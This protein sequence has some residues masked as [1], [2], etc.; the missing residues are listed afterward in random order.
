RVI[1]AGAI[2]MSLC[3]P[4][5]DFTHQPI[6]FAALVALA[7]TA[8][9]LKVTLPLTASG[10][11]MSVSYAVDFA[12]LLL[13]GPHE[14]MVVAVAS[15]FCQSHVNTKDR[16]PLYRTIFNMAALVLTVQGAGLALLWLT[17]PSADAVSMIARPL[18]GAATTYFVLN[19]AIIATA[20]AFST[21]QPILATW[22]TNFLW[23][24][25]R[26]TRRAW[27]RP[28][29]CRRRRFR[30]SKPRPCFMT[31]GSWLFRNTSCRSP[32]R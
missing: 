10:S 23:G 19:T 20:I 22:Q 30:E 14:T 18:V 2:V 7:S 21:A 17:D 15:A 24:A 9:A 26:C 3:L 4:L 12:A 28:S 11:T 5:A 27:R 8:A 25:S 6:L 16:N 32:G 29:G 1:G 31:S 13:L